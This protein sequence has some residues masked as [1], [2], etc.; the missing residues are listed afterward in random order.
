MTSSQV[1]T[2]QEKDNVE[3]STTRELIEPR[4]LAQENP[5][6]GCDNKMKCSKKNSSS[7]EVSKPRGAGEARGGIAVG[8]YAWQCENAKLQNCRGATMAYHRTFFLHG[9]DI[10]SWARGLLATN[11]GRP[12]TTIAAVHILSDVVEV[13]VQVWTGKQALSHSLGR[14]TTI[15]Q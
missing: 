14:L 5:V 4:R 8:K 3:E 13:E 12:T 7:V 15:D 6:V 1:E 9:C 11:V 10:F 2:P